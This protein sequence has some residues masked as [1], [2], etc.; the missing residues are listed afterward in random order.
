[1]NQNPLAMFE[2]MALDQGRL[3]GFYQSVFGWEV[4]RNAEGFAYIKF[5]ATPSGGYPMLGGIGKARPGIPGYEK[6]TAFYFQV[7]SITSTLEVIVQQG[8][9]IVMPATAVDGYTF[10]M[11]TDPENNLIGLIEPF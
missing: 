11:F 3:I 7:P 10:G 8:G 9:A 1:M 6:G 4:V 5:P 2:I